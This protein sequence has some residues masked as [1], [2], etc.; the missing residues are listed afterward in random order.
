MSLEVVGIALVPIIVALI[1]LAKRVGLPHEY[2]R[3]ANL[4]L[5][6]VGVL[7]VQAVDWNPEWGPTVKT[8]L[9]MLMMFLAAAGLYREGVEKPAE[10]GSG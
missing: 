3:W 7:L 4:V 6:V 8:V 1:Q 10:N 9:D 5:S 2:A